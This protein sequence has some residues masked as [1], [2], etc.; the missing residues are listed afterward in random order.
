VS[1]QLE[2]EH[3]E[4]ARE[5]IRKHLVP[6]AVIVRDGYAKEDMEQC[7]DFVMNIA[8][9][10]GDVLCR[11]RRKQFLERFGAQFSIRYRS[12]SGKPTEIHKLREGKGR[13]Y[14][15]GYSDGKAKFAYWRIFDINKMREDRVFDDMNLWTIRSNPDGS[16][17]M[18]CDIS[19]LEKYIVASFGGKD[20]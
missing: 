15:F 18:Y 10:T 17:G 3:R 6:L 14:L 2:R 19:K 7:K 9:G 13:W 16:K 1:F 4:A 8:V 12:R 5:I 11:V 20:E